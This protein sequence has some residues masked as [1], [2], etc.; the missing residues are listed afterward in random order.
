MDGWVIILFGA[1]FLAAIFYASERDNNVN[2]Q[3]IKPRKLGMSLEWGDLSK[4]EKTISL[5][6]L[7]LII[8]SLVYF[9]NM[10]EPGTKSEPESITIMVMTQGLVENNLKAPSTAKHPSLS[11]YSI[12]N[13]GGGKY[14]VSSYVD[15]QNS[16]GAMLRQEYTAII[17]HVGGDGDKW[18]L[19]SV[20]FER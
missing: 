2:K 6:A 5:V 8:F 14:K 11:D 20:Q 4:K 16:F 17:K 19:E 9:S 13:L 10:M 3:G 7:A 18:I 15:S 12:D 1:V